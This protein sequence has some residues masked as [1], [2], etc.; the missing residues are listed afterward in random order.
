MNS[1][2]FAR[3]GE[4]HSIGHSLAILGEDAIRHW[5]ALAALP[6][7]A[8]DKPGELVTHSL[9]RARFSR[10]VVAT[11]GVSEHGQGFL[12]GLFLLLD[13]LMDVPLEEA[14][15]QAGVGPLISG[16]LAGNRRGK[17]M[18]PLRHVYIWSAITKRRLEGRVRV[19]V[20]MATK[21]SCVGEAYS[22]STL[23]AQQA[24]H[25]TARKTNS[26]RKVR[27]AAQGP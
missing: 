11:A 1:A 10:T 6:I 7:L 2:L 8:K 16:A 3:V 14:L 22:E 19:G 15:R 9:V 17:R 24:L 21:A 5:V 20:E 18:T 23:W 27:H 25:A 26:R 13:A 4:I 12:M